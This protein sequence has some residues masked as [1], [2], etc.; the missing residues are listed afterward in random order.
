LFK[1]LNEEGTWQLLLR[2]KYLSSKTLSKVHV[3]PKDS[4]FWKGILMVKEQFLKSGAFKIKDDCQTRFWEDS[5][6]G[7]T[8][9]KEQFPSIYNIANYP[10]VIVANVLNHTPLNISFR[11]ALVRDKLVAWYNLVAKVSHIQLIIE[12]DVFTWNL[13]NMDNS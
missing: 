2:S 11:R 4:Q 5:W 9:L 1:L 12:N 13:H 3:K 8:S 10:H 6:I 7:S